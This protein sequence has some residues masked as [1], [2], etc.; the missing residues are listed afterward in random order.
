MRRVAL[1]LGNGA[2]ACSSSTPKGEPIAAA[3][4]ESGKATL[5]TSGNCE[6]D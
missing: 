4:I 6:E 5:F 2:P 3:S 1:V